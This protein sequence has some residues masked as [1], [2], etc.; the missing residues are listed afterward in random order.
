MVNACTF[1]EKKKKQQHKKWN[2]CRTLHQGLLLKYKNCPLWEQVHCF[3][4]HYWNIQNTND[5][6]T[7]VQK[8]FYFLQSWR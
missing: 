7:Y 2:I 5:T 1:T 6:T 8:E 4:T 3:K